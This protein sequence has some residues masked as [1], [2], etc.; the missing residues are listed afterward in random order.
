M[1]RRAMRGNTVR[2]C[3]VTFDPQSIVVR[4]DKPGSSVQYPLAV[5]AFAL[6]RF[7]HKGRDE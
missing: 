6:R 2:A 5:D 7:T 1:R 4:P 3:A